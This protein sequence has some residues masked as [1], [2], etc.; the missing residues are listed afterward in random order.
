MGLLIKRNPIKL[1]PISNTVKKLLFS[2]L[3]REIENSKKPQIPIVI[4]VLKGL[5][6]LMCVIFPEEDESKNLYPTL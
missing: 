1:S 5:K 4:G 3:F 2:E 6:Y